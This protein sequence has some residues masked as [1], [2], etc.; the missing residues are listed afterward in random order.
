VLASYRGYGANT[1]DPSEAGVIGGCARDPG[2]AAAPTRAVILWG[3]S[4][5]SGVAAAM[6]AR[7]ALPR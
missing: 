7:A 5:G 6:A 2:G 1:G 3:Q 4:L